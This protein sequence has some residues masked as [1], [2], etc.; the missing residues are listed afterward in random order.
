MNVKKTVVGEVVSASDGGKVEKAAEGIRAVNPTSVIAWEVPL[1][2]DDEKTL[3]Y[4]Y[5]T[6]VRY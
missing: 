6:Y 3:D 2:P 1:D 5:F 4:T